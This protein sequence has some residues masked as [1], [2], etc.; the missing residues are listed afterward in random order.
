MDISAT[1]GSENVAIEIETG[2]SDVVANVKRDLLCGV[3]KVVVVA[4]D[5]QALEKIERQL[6]KASLLI[7]GRVEVGL[8]SISDFSI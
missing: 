3:H 6:A 7:P 1:R 8:G 2:K 5:Q 4:T